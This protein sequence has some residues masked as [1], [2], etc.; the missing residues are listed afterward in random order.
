ME[1][2]ID[3]FL[4]TGITAHL[5]LTSDSKTLAFYRTNRRR[6]GA[7]G[8]LVVDKCK[9]L[10]ESGCKG[11]CMNQCKLPAQVTSDNYFS[12]M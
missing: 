7:L 10:Q 3:R 8:G 9:F 11:M 4:A 6:D 2:F 5:S 1:V 12:E